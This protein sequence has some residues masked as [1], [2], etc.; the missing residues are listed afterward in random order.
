[1]SERYTR[2]F[3]DDLSRTGLPSARR[4]VPLLAAMMEL[5]SVIDVGCGNGAWLSVFAEHGARRIVGL[6]N[7]WIGADQLLI[8]AAAFQR[9]DLSRPLP[10]EG[11][12]DLALSLEVA[13]HLPPERAA[14][15]VAELARL[16][17][18]VLF[19]AAIP[20]QGGVNHRNEQWPGYWAALFASHGYRAIDT[21]RPRIWAMPEV[22]WWYKQNLVLFASAAAIAA[23]PAL[24]AALEAS[25]PGAP[26]A[27]VHPEK[28]L[29][30]ER[31]TR[32]GLGRWLKMGRAALRRSLAP[33]RRSG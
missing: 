12:F 8:D 1:V 15:F 29:A 33:G 21:L 30:T 7:D 13:E 10:A 17:P 20:G 11:P 3:Y 16:A 32:P 27:L 14:S 25:P 9:C 18:V 26:L 19:S 2:E 22:T 23:N 6:D 28:F 5:S 24:A 4:I 31:L